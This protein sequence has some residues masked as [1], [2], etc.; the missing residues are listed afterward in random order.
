M[1]SASA[2]GA[3]VVPPSGAGH[4]ASLKPGVW[5]NI[6]PPQVSL[7]YVTFQNYGVGAFVIDPQ[8]T[9]T[10]FLGTS[11]Q[12][13]YKTTDSGATWGL[14]NTGKNG[15]QLTAGRQW[16]MTIDPVDPQ[17]LYTNAGYGPGGVWKSANGG[18]DWVQTLSP[19]MLQVFIFQGFVESITMDPTDHLH[20]IASPHFTC[21]STY[22]TAH[23]IATNCMLE[24][25]DGGFTWAVLQGTPD[26]LHS[27]SQIM[28]DHD[29]WL[30]AQEAGNLFR[31]SDAGVTWTKLVTTGAVGVAPSLYHASNGTYY[32]PSFSGILESRDT[33][34]WRLLANTPRSET[35]TGD[36]TNLYVSR[37]DLMTNAPYQP[38]T[39]APETDPT[40]WQTYP[41]PSMNQGGAIAYDPNHHILYSTNQNAGFWRVVTH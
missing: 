13:I 7:P 3:H 14:I 31:T 35:I 32:M 15:P 39:A 30:W 25:K 40:H 34:N 21:E 36:G 18:I 1:G 28:L 16:T 33:I 26:S 6:T 8:R 17:V 19:D 38:Y 27:S 9:S 12:G 2:P 37:S 24:T 5:E 22:D 41:S 29:N 23:G 4:A 11:A 10:I 20:L